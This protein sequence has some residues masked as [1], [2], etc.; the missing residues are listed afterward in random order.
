MPAKAASPLS[1]GDGPAIQMEIVDHR[2]TE[3]HG[4]GGAAATVYRNLLRK[5]IDGQ[6]TRLS[7]GGFRKAIALDIQDV[8]SIAT[9]AGDPT[10][11][12]DAI[13]EMLNTLD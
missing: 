4:S 10:R 6:T 2:K 11:Y 7:T 13:R 9:K 12:D 8:K 1:E 5:L 3:S